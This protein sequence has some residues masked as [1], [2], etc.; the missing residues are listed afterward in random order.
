M[1]ALASNIEPTAEC[2]AIVG[3]GATG[4]SCARFLKKHNRP[5]LLLDTRSAPPGIERVFAEFGDVDLILGDLPID[6]LRRVSHLI[7]SPGISLDLPP[8]REAIECGV[9]LFSDLD[10]FRER[11]TQPLVCITGSNGKSTVASWVADMA[12]RAGW[13][14]GLCGNIGLP[15]LDALDA[16]RDCYVVELSSFQLERSQAPNADVA[17]LLNVSADHM[18]R[19]QSLADYAA[20]KRRIFAGAKVCVIGHDQL[21]ASSADIADSVSFSSEPGEQADYHLRISDKKLSLWHGDRELFTASD[22]ALAGRH[23]AG[24]ALAAI[25]AAQAIGIPESA[26]LESLAEFSGLSHRC[27]LVA[28]RRGVRFINDSKGTNT[29]ATA[30]ALKSFGSAERANIILILGGVGKGAD[31]TE[32][33][34]LVSQYAR[35]VVVYG[36]DRE[37]IVAALGTAGKIVRVAGLREAVIEAVAAAQPGDFVLFSPACASFDMFANFAERGEV[38]KQLVQA[39]LQDQEADFG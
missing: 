4:L 30:T 29:G 17:V 27:E 26:I 39:Q 21:E 23:N 22:L 10:L 19:Y 31:F 28:E 16:S 2:Y 35:R 8:I 3:V 14:V 38:F 9:S 18:D 15:M 33:R 11:V 24:N 12:E 7:V 1:T 34:P 13:N 20:A 32:L 6:V 25:A 36:Q 37:Q 5:F